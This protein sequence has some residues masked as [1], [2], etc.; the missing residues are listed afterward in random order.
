[1]MKRPLSCSSFAL[2]AVLATAV[3]AFNV[4][5]STPSLVVA[6]PSSNK[7]DIINITFVKEVT[8]TVQPPFLGEED[9]SMPIVNQGKIDDFLS[10]GLKLLDPLMRLFNQLWGPAP[11]ETPPVHV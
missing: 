7:N 3:R 1:M 6:A 10:A 9:L 8:L 5:D 11:A 2:L 4:S